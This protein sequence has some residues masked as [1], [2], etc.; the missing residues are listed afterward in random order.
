MRFAQAFELLD[1]TPDETFLLRRTPMCA[2]RTKESNSEPMACHERAGLCSPEHNPRVEWWRRG[3]L[4]PCPK[5]VS[6]SDLHV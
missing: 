1:V 5:T 4:N 6:T 3:E 2:T